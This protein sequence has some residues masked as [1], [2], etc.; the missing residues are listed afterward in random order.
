MSAVN[1]LEIKQNT[2][3]PKTYFELLLTTIYFKARYSCGIEISQF[4]LDT[5]FGLF[6]FPIRPKYYNLRHFYF[7]VVLKIEILGSWV[8]NISEILGE[9]GT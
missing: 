3:P 2:G 6:N 9:V 8:S 4:T 7:M 1:I 5:T